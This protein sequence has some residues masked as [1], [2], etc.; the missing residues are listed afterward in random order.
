M[1]GKTS[2]LRRSRNQTI[3]LIVGTLLLYA[4][5]T[6]RLGGFVENLPTIIFDFIL[7]LVG[8]FLF[9]SFFSQF[10]LPVRTLQERNNAFNRLFNYFAGTHG[11]AIFV[12][13]GTVRSREQE[14]H[15]RGPGVIVLDSAS[16]GVLRNSAAFTRSIGPGIIFTKGSEYLAGT[17]D[18]HVQT[19][20][21]GPLE[22]EDPFL[23]QRKEDS[24]ESYQR[25]QERRWETSGLTRDGVEVIPSIAVRFRLDAESG[26][27][28]TMYGFNPRAVWQAIASEAIDPDQPPDAHSRHI[29]WNWLPVYLAADLWREYLRK[30]TLNELF[31]IRS[32]SRGDAGLENRQTVFEWIEGLVFARLTEEGVENLDEVGRPTSQQISS[33]EFEI[34]KDRGIRVLDI[35]ITNLRFPAS[36]ED[37]LQGNWK[38]TWLERAQQEREAIVRQRSYEKLLGEEKGL[39]DFADASS[40]YLGP[41]L[42]ENAN[43]PELLPDEADTLELLVRGSLNLCNR[44]SE[45]RPRLTTEKTQLIELI[46]W[47]RRH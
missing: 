39:L 18:L 42:T 27:G 13:N 45:L 3:L 22:H 24:L 43:M 21:L 47:I 4:F 11:P 33:R 6:Y 44:D 7:F 25:R 16:A 23:P 38:A 19:R 2:F 20:R 29:P 28:G 26:M 5:F 37:Q 32:I 10:T 40:L 46:E 34:L 35:S 8:F 41:I 12:E 30:F 36:V 9:M 15:R 1:T 17:V 31:T 14:M